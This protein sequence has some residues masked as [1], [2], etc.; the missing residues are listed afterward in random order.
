[1]SFCNLKTNLHICV[2]KK[3]LNR[4]K[5]L[6]YSQILS[7][8]TLLGPNSDERCFQGGCFY[9]IRKNPSFLGKFE[10]NFNEKKYPKIK[11]EGHTWSYI[12]S[13]CQILFGGHFITFKAIV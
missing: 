4:S 1:V 13:K 12:V 7:R 9:P 5:L 10:V 8:S 6:V 2:H 3:A 11:L